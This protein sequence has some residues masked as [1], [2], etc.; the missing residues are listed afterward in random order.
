MQTLASK[1]I[2][3]LALSINEA[4][5]TIG[6]SRATVYKEITAGRLRTFQINSRRLV[7][8]TEIQNYIAARE[9]ETATKPE[10]A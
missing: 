1:T 8:V 5:Q 7:S 3:P 4:A 2:P 6:I 9:A 10:A